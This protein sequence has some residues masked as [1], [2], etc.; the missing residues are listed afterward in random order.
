MV[1][2]RTTREVMQEPKI[3][4]HYENGELLYASIWGGLVVSKIALDGKPE[5]G[6]DAPRGVE[7]PGSSSAS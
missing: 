3:T 6:H 2:M 4:L 7:Q 1:T 5:L